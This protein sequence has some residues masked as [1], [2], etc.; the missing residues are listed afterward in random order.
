MFEM[1]SKSKVEACSR[2]FYY[3]IVKENRIWRRNYS[4]NSG[5]YGQNADWNFYFQF[6]EI[7]LYVGQTIFENKP[8]TYS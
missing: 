1:G 7:E 6:H 2:G 5:I 8:G 4:L 3:A